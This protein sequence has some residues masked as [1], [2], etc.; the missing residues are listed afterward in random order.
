MGG[1]KGA[2]FIEAYRD[3]YEQRLAAKNA[4]D[5]AVADS[6]KISL[7]GLFGKLG[8]KYSP[9]YSPDLLL[10]VTL[11][12]QLNL[13]TLIDDLAKQSGIFVLSANTDGVMVGY[14]PS[15]R[16]KVLATV[17]ANAS[18]TNFEYEEKRYDKVALKDV[19]NYIAVMNSGE[20]KA[21]G[22]YAE[23]GLQKNPTMSVCSKAVIQFL[24]DGTPPEMSIQYAEDFSDF[25]AIRAVRGGGEQA[26]V[27]LGRVA[28]WY[29]TTDKIPPIQYSSNGNKVPKTDGARAC[30][31]LPDSFPDD[32]DYQWYIDESYNILTS[33]GVAHERTA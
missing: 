25:T 4:G 9:F 27:E 22:L 32:L 28:R 33:L 6:L 21:K 24:V 23:A 30:M 16:V 2:V 14:H 8:S 3:I 26:G 17:A 15:L 11:T 20:V 7:N 31:F 1:G 5:K 10:M 13:L 19:N 12:G 18:E 29:M